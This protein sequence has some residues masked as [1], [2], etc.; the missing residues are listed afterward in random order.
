VIEKIRLLKQT[1][2]PDNPYHLALGLGLEL[3]HDFL[4]EKGQQNNTTHIVFERRGK[5]ASALIRI[6]PLM[7]KKLTQPPLHSIF[8]SAF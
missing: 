6:D 5:K 3:I 8:C 7:L 1:S 4:E 2:A